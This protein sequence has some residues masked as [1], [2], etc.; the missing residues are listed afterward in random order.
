MKQGPALPQVKASPGM[1]SCPFV[2][3]GIAR[4]YNKMT[5]SLEYTFD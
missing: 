4:H 2:T 3:G 1:N 5:G